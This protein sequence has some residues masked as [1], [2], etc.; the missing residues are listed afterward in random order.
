MRSGSGLTFVLL[1]TLANY[2]LAGA[3]DGSMEPDWA[4]ETDPGEAG[5]SFGS[6]IGLY[7]AGYV[8]YGPWTRHL[9]AGKEYSGMGHPDDLTQVGPGGGGSLELGFKFGINSFALQLDFS[10]LTATDWEDYA[11][12]QGNDLSV[13]LTKWDLNILWGIELFGNRYIMLEARAGLGYMVVEGSEHDDYYR[14]SYDY[15]FLRHSFSIRAGLS[16]NVS[17]S[18]GLMISLIVD[19]ALGIPGIEYRDEEWSRLYLG[20]T[21]SLGLRLWPQVIWGERP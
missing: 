15:D 21:F 14:L 13:D 9:L 4:E 18:K 11:S 17:I 16:A 12:H 10:C 7:G 6:F 2:V 19:H 3:V 8:P 20:F 1:L 5:R